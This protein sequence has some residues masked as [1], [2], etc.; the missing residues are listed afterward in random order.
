MYFRQSQPHSN[1]GQQ[2]SQQCWGVA[3]P[4]LLAGAPCDL[5]KQLLACS[6]S[7]SVCARAL[8]LACQFL[9]VFFPALPPSLFQGQVRE[10][11]ILVGKDSTDQF[12]VTVPGEGPSQGCHGLYLLPCARAFSGSTN[13]VGTSAQAHLLVISLTA[14]YVH[15]TCTVEPFVMLLKSVLKLSVKKIT[16]IFLG[17]QQNCWLWEFVCELIVRSTMPWILG[18]YI[19]SESFA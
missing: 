16:N 12:I 13:F 5:Y 8:L 1:A 14:T 18:V 9:W 2:F 6:S 3:S 17:C 10:K 7:Q 15:C 4:M 19:Y 11:N